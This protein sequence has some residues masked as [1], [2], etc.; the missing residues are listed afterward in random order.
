MIKKVYFQDDLDEINCFLISI[1][2]SRIKIDIL[3]GKTK[4]IGCVKLKIEDKRIYLTTMYDTSINPE[5]GIDIATSRLIEFLLKDYAGSIII[6]ENRPH[7]IENPEGKITKI[8]RPISLSSLNIYANARF[9]LI[10][11]QDIFQRMIDGIKEE[12]FKKDGLIPDYLIYKKLKKRLLYRY[13]LGDDE[14]I[15]DVRYDGV[16]YKPRNKIM[17]KDH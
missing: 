11:H 5:S 13:Y 7:I 10:R 15:Y 12:D 17:T 8:K 3:D 14:N 2:E 6:V 16:N 1:Q 9:K 4:F